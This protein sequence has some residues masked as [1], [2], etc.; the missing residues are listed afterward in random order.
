MTLVQCIAGGADGDAAGVA[1]PQQMADAMG[2]MMAARIIGATVR[3]VGITAGQLNVIVYPQL[4]M[5]IRGQYHA[6]PKDRYDQPDFEKAR[7]HGKTGS[8]QCPPVYPICYRATMLFGR[9]TQ[10]HVL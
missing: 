5:H 10:D 7:Q 8:G 9:C 2:A 1:Q 3:G 4:I 6:I